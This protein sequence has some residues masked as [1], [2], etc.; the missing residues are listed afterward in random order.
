MTNSKAVQNMYQYM[1]IVLIF[2]SSFQPKDKFVPIA[3]QRQLVAKQTSSSTARN[4]C[5][6]CNTTLLSKILP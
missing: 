3:R 6:K 5:G 4:Q 1:Y 2:P